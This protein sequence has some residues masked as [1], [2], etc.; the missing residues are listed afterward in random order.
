MLFK[1]RLKN[2]SELKAFQ[3]SVSN[4]LAIIEDPEGESRCTLRPREWSICQNHSG[5]CEPVSGEID[6]ERQWEEFSPHYKEAFFI[7]SFLLWS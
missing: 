3:S 7:G 5:I 2:A 4:V 1:A 6:W